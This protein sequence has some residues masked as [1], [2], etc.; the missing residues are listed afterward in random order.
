[1]LTWRIWTSGP[2]LPPASFSRARLTRR[3]RFINL[4][5]AVK[6]HIKQPR[7]RNRGRFCKIELAPSLLGS[8]RVCHVTRR[9]QRLGGS[10]NRQIRVETLIGYQAEFEI[11]NK[12]TLFLSGNAVLQ[13]LFKIKLILTQKSIEIQICGCL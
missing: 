7:K 9:D 3:L 1:M 8:I 5:R 11:I 4:S 12:I 13:K 2:H 10:C 6:V